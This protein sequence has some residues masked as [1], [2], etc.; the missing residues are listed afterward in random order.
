MAD[1]DRFHAIADH[2]Y[3][4]VQNERNRTA[5][6]WLISR[7]WDGTD[8]EKATPG[9][10]FDRLFTKDDDDSVFRALQESD[11]YTNVFRRMLKPITTPEALSALV[12][13][14][15]LNETPIV[16]QLKKELDNLIGDGAGKV[17]E[18]K[19]DARD[20]IRKAFMSLVRDNVGLPSVNGKDFMSANFPLLK[21]LSA[22]REKWN[23]LLSH[24]WNSEDARGKVLDLFRTYLGVEKVVWDEYHPR[25]VTR[26]ADARTQW[27]DVVK[28]A[29]RAADDLF[30][31]DIIRKGLRH[32]NQIIQ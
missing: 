32:G 25:Y 5:Y 20:A 15:A 26:D 11:S 6:D 28:K 30:A 14:P 22:N 16:D 13:V 18:T 21:V 12:A 8:F 3:E 2:L 9:E 17:Y 24:R 10:V 23:R 1:T 4:F 19:D 31:V 7:G 27:R 29:S